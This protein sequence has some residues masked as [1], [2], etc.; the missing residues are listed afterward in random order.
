MNDVTLFASGHTFHRRAVIAR[1]DQVTHWTPARV[2]AIG[3]TPAL[4]QAR[5]P[6]LQQVHGS[7][8]KDFLM[9]QE[10]RRFRFDRMLLSAF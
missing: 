4:Q 5:S 8:V 7:V 3:A 6:L 9:A 2:T 1:L 10:R